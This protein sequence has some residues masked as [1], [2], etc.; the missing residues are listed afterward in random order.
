MLADLRAAN[1]A[2]APASHVASMTANGTP[3]YTAKEQA[4]MRTGDV[5]RLRWWHRPGVRNLPDIYCVR[6]HD[7][8]AS[9]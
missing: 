9:L 1:L 4:A 3:A 6:P 8:L 2:H 5:G 7:G